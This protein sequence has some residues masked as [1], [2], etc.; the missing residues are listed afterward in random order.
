MEHPLFSLWKA[1]RKKVSICVSIDGSSYQYDDEALRY[2]STLNL[3]DQFEVVYVSNVKIDC[4]EKGPRILIPSIGPGGGKE[5]YRIDLK[6]QDGLYYFGSGFRYKEIREKYPPALLGSMAIGDLTFTKRDMRSRAARE[7][8]QNGFYGAGAFVGDASECL[9][10]MR[11]WM[12]KR[13]LVTLGKKTTFYIS[14]SIAA[15]LAL[16]M[17]LPNCEKA[18][19]AAIVSRKENCPLGEGTV[20][21]Y[22]GSI[23]SRTK[24]LLTT[25]DLLEVLKFSSFDRYDTRQDDYFYLVN[26]YFGYFLVL[27]TGVIDSVETLSYWRICD[28]QKKPL[29]VSFRNL[30]DKKQHKMSFLKKMSLFNEDLTKYIISTEVRSLL[31]IIYSLRNQ[32]AHEILPAT[33]TYVGNSGGLSGDLVI[34]TGNSVEKMDNYSKVHNLSDYQ[35]LGLGIEMRGKGRISDKKEIWVEPVLFARNILVEVLKLIDNVLGYVRLEDLIISTTEEMEK[36]QELTKSPL[37]ESGPGPFEKIN[38]A[39][40]LIEASVP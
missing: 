21:G 16:H 40:T 26:Y 20:Y 22:I 15:S 6:R 1:I 9:S 12:N 31:D 27:L 30:E 5:E 7:L 38:E 13:G 33:M 19:R 18:W 8:V 10:A 39:M 32:V 35:L 11:A 17:L 28:R 23:L 3:F 2:L 37:A 34:L 36:C 25:R 29:G 4:I 14:R 24:H